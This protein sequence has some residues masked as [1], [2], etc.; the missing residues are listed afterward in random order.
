MRLAVGVPPALA[1]KTEQEYASSPASPLGRQDAEVLAAGILRDAHRSGPR[2]TTIARIYKGVSGVLEAK[3][4]FR[5][6]PGAFTKGGAYELFAQYLPNGEL[7]Q[8]RVSMFSHLGKAWR[9]PGWSQ[10][11]GTGDLYTFRILPGST[12]VIWLEYANRK[13]AWRT[14]EVM[15]PPLN[16]EDEE[17]ELTIPDL[18][19]LYGQAVSIVAKAEH[20]ASVTPPQVLSPGL[21]WGLTRGLQ[22]C[23][24]GGPW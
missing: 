21:P 22:A 5:A 3:V 1:S 19:E 2:R 11:I 15:P 13:E 24:P 12:V 7:V 10:K 9:W 14:G 4:D 8:A 20:H 6:K 18:E 17:A 16:S 23:E